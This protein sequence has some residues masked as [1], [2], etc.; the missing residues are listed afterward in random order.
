MLNKTTT[1]KQTNADPD[2]CPISKI[3]PLSFDQEANQIRIASENT[4][5]PF[6]II[7]K[8]L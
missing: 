7:V 6:L 5:L 1:R 8:F 3:E 4:A 2:F